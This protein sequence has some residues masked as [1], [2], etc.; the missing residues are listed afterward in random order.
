MCVRRSPALT[1][2]TLTPQHILL[3]SDYLQVPK[4]RL[5]PQRHAV[6][7]TGCD[8]GFGN[9]LARKLDKAGF[10]VYACCLFPDGDGAKQLEADCSALLQVVKLDVTSDADVDEASKRVGLDLEQSA[11]RK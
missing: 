4:L 1:C 11:Y 6:L 10:K 8:T 3:A 7:I 2:N 5:G 9:L